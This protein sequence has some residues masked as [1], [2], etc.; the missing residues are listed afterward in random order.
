MPVVLY[1]RRG[2]HLCE[3]AE[4]IL[5]AAG[6]QVRLVDV[7]QDAGVATTYGLRIPVVEIDGQTVL[8]GWFDERQLAAVLARFKD[9][10]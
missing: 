6:L 5:A 10:D 3:A 1:T 9:R 8:E 7:D 2:C 4:D